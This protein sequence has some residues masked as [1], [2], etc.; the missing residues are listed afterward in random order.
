MTCMKCRKEK[1][2]VPFITNIKQLIETLFDASKELFRFFWIKFCELSNSP[3]AT[4][5][6]NDLKE[7]EDKVFFKL[8]KNKN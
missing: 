8:E 3:M 4:N 1:K 2:D 6:T 7:I 5:N